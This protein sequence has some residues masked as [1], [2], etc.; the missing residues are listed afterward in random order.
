MNQVCHRGTYE[1]QTVRQ[2][3]E[4]RRSER[5]DPYDDDDY[6]NLG[7]YADRWGLESYEQKFGYRLCISVKENESPPLE[8]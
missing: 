6:W 1:S 7:R 2:V 5:F 4:R 3:G 8:K